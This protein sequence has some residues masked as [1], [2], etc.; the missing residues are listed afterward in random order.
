LDLL[1][2]AHLTSARAALVLTREEV[3]RI[4]QRI[5]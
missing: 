1:A 2:D 5:R 4:L 3:R